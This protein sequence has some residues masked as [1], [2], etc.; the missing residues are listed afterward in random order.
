MAK[1]SGT[2]PSTVKRLFWVVIVGIL[3]YVVLDT[4]AQILPPY[5]SPVSQ[6]ESYLAIGPYGYI[7]TLNF[8]N[9]GLFS[10]VF[11]YAMLRAIDLRGGVRNRYRAGVALLGVWAVG[12][13]ILAAFPTDVPPS[14]PTLSG[15]IHLVVAVISFVGGS[16]GA[17]GL[18]LQFKRD[19]AFQRVT[20]FALPISLLAVALVFLL[21]GLPGVAP[22][23]AQ[24]MNGL[25]E[26]VFL[27]SV[28]LW[29]L[30]LSVHLS[31]N[32]SLSNRA[33][34]A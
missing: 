26:R 29:M 20:R 11:L 32:S 31:G 12:A 13:F 16:F 30:A 23:F 33:K 25:L 27:A 5:Y 7:M 24:R 22:A 19:P 21:F 8:L 1:S 15:A 10:L 28:L 4:A 6:A 2:S 18:S 14:A 9:R 34:T 17:L 3:L